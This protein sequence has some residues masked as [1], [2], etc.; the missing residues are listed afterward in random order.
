VKVLLDPGHAAP[1]LQRLP[2]GTKRRLKSALR[3]LGQDPS[4]ISNRLDVKRLDAEPGQ[5]IYRLR[6]GD[7]R[8]AFTIDRDV[9]VLRI[10]HRREGYGW[11]ADMS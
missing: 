9:V 7:W 8:I 3:A 1:A 11:L 6:V 4:G 10:F 5:P 2:P